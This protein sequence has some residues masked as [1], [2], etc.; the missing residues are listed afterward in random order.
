MYLSKAVIVPA[1]DVVQ[2]VGRRRPW[3]VIARDT[4]LVLRLV[5]SD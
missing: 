2:G 3:A 5:K 1:V 4:L